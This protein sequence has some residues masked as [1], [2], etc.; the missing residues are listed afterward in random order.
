MLTEAAGRLGM[1]PAIVEKDFW[2]C[3]ILK[4][5]FSEPEL[6]GKMVF[7]GGTSLS[8]VHGLIDRFRRIST[9][10]AEPS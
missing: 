2:V 1:N 7:K 4:R 10:S 8:R 6:R 9:S 5:L 3:W